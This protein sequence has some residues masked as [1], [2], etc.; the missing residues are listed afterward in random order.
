MT[1]QI[2]PVVRPKV[3]VVDDMAANREL[4]Q[5]HLDDLGYEVREARDGI[6]ALEA[7]AAEEPDL[8]LLDIDMPR[9]DGIAVCEQLKAHPIRRMIPIVILTAS[10]D[11]TTKLRG[12]AAGADDYLSKPFDS[13]E[14]LIR[15]KVLLRQR[16]LNQRLDATEGV[17]FALARAIEA[18]DRH[19]IHHAER[20]GRYAEAIGA[21]QGLSHKDGEL[22]Y[23]GGVLHDLGKIAIPDAILLK[24][25]PLTASEFSTMRQHSVEGERICLS[26]R[27][28]SHY[29]PIIRHHHERVDGTGY[30]DH[31]AG[32]DIPI[33]ARITAIADG[34]DAMVSDRPYRAGL[35]EDEALRRLRQGAGTQWDA[36]L[37]RTFVD[38]LDGGLTRRVTESQLAAIA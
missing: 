33:G 36:G 32:T 13:K 35:D 31:L 3:L 28:V 17:L 7:V 34:W 10:N 21:A 5:G 9:L 1:N 12:I 38:L 4:L 6:E 8:I 30:P 19:T 29:L 18:R 14:L 2:A 23:Q 11:R 15:T 16:A 37:V 20:V 27:S 25:G 24:P 26:L 22:L